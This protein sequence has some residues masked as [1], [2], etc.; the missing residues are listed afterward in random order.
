MAVAVV[1]V[2]FDIRYNMSFLVKKY[3]IL[4]RVIYRNS[5]GEFDYVFECFRM[6][7]GFTKFYR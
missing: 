5:S 1:F 7:C 2:R 6:L 4:R 3:Y